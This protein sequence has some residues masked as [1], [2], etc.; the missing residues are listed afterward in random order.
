MCVLV[1]YFLHLSH[2]DRRSKPA[3][4]PSGERV[5]ALE[6]TIEGSLE[7]AKRAYALQN[8]EHAVEHYATALELMYV[9][10]FNAFDAPGR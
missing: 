4:I 9:R 2:L 10:L 6:V 8:F 5:A 3:P 7:L 1:I